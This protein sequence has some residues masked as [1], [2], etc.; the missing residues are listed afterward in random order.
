VTDSIRQKSCSAITGSIVTSWKAS[1]TFSKAREISEKRSG[2][3]CIGK[4][5]EVQI[6]NLLDEQKKELIGAFR[7]RQQIPPGKKEK[8]VETKREVETVQR[9][10][11]GYSVSVIPKVRTTDGHLMEWDRNAIVHQLR[12]ETKLGE[13][14]H[15]KPA[16]TEEEAREI[17][18][19]TEKRIK[20]MGVKFLSGPLVRELVNIILLERGH[21][22]W[23]NISTR[24]G[25]PV[26]DAYKIDMGTGFEA[27][28]NANL[29][30]NAETSHKKKADKMSKEQYLLMLP[31]KLADAHLNGD[32]HIHDLEYL[33]TRAFCLDATATIPILMKGEFSF[34]KAGDFDTM[35]RKPEKI[36]DR[37]L[38]DVSFLNIKF[39]GPRGSR[40][41]L[42]VYRKKTDE[43]ILALRTNLGKTLRLSK[44]HP[45]I[46]CENG[47]LLERRAGDTKEGTAL[48]TGTPVLFGTLPTKTN[49]VRELCNKATEE[50]IENV[51]A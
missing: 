35:F 19:E 27:K 14:F 15:L 37:E 10:L 16:I 38:V 48:A 12:K 8:K 5:I 30:E 13:Q 42:R 44:D 1:L 43:K 25:T 31:P 29:Q 11:G 18:K 7:E 50:E 49:L 22:E 32:I 24:V 28:D 45:V 34:A 21:T 41:L 33:G 2:G 47:A 4:Y 9:T 26:Y 39:F 6:S 20:D 17:A 51:Y 3:I 46:V 23:R 40:K 36:E